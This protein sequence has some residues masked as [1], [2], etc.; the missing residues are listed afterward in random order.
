MAGIDLATAE[1][2]L[3]FWLNIEEQLGVNASVTIDGT[4]YTRHQLRDVQACIT[5]W[6]ERVRRLSAS[7]AAGGRRVQRIVPL[8]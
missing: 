6:D 5:T 8:S 3:A 7:A 2:K 4:T 1:T